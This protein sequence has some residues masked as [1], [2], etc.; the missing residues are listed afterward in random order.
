MH[1]AELEAW[2][3]GKEINKQFTLQL[4]RALGHAMVIAESVLREGLVLGNMELGCQPL[5]L[6]IECDDPSGSLSPPL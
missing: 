6:T 4:M 3:L 1:C 2:Q 5:E